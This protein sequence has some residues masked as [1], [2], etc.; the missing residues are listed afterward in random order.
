MTHD[1]FPPPVEPPVAVKEARRDRRLHLCYASYWGIALR[2][3]IIAAELSG[4]YLLESRLLLVDA[5]SSMIDVISSIVLILCIR[6]AARPPDEEH[7]FG[8][9]RLEPIAGMQLGVFL[10]A[11]GAI[12]AL[13]LLWDMGMGEA[14]LYSVHHLTWVIAL[15]AA[16]VLYVGYWIVHRAA[17]QRR[18]AAL[19][20]EAMHYRIDAVNSLMAAVALFAA[21]HIPSL[22]VQIDQIGA[23]VISLWMV[24]TGVRATQD[25]FHQVMDRVP[26]QE[27]FERVREAA[28]RV[29]GVLD[30]EKIRI[31]HCGPDA[32]VDIDIEVQPELPVHAAHAISQQVRFEI[33]RVWPAV[34]EVV[35]HIEPYYPGDH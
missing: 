3:L 24:W 15:V 32:H 20:S 2:I 18:S 33:Q 31:Q 35:V 10:V 34:R 9:G 19:H 6:I 23:L 13:Q 21:G 17:V 5:L 29:D 4:F 14:D 30:T 16:A 11:A 25:N 26:E 7:P 27:Y 12:A 1:Q 22:G 28:L 8:H